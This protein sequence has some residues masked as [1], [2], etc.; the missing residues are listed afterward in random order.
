MYSVINIYKPIQYFKL[1]SD[2]LVIMC[3]IVKPHS[4]KRI[5]IVKTSQFS[6][7][8]YLF[9]SELLRALLTI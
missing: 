7:N 8:F 3:N 4:S 5:D 9:S 6:N 1:F 2:F